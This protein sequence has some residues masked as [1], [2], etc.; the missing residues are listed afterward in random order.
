F[1]ESVQQFIPAR[2]SPTR[3]SIFE[4]PLK[5]GHTLRLLLG[6]TGE[7]LVQCFQQP[8]EFRTLGR[9]PTGFRP[10]ALWERFRDRARADLSSLGASWLQDLPW[11]GPESRGLA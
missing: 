9:P 10:V 8:F 4:Q 11:L 5:R 1:M 3:Q 7:L 2:P 6:R